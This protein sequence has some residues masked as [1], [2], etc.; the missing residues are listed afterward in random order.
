VF[1][2]SLAAFACHVQPGISDVSLNLNAVVLQ[3]HPWHMWWCLAIPD[4]SVLN[5]VIEKECKQFME[6]FISALLCSSF[7][8]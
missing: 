4:I 7:G 3:K 6:A 1:A 2:L 8:P 5:Y